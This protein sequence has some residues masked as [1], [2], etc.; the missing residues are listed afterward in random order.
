VRILFIGGLNEFRKPRGGEEFKNQLI[1]EA[2]LKTHSLKIADTHHWL[3]RPLFLLR[4]F[5]HLFISRNDKIVLSAS[6]LSSSRLIR[7]S[8]YFPKIQRKIVYIVVGGYFFDAIADNIY[9]KKYYHGLDSIIVQSDRYKIKLNSIGLS[10]VIYLP[11]FKKIPQIEFLE[12]L[13]V[14]NKVKF[15]FV[16]NISESKGVQLIFEAIRLLDKTKYSGEYEID[17]YGNI[18]PD[19][20]KDFIKSLSGNLKYKGYLD[21]KND[22]VK[23]YQ[24]LASY[25]CMLFPTM[26]VGEGFPGV[27]IDAFISSLPVIASDWH[28]NSEFIKNN[29]NGFLVASNS[30]TELAKAMIVVLDDPA[31]LVDMSK[32]SGQKAMLYSLDE[33]W[34]KLEDLLQKD[35]RGSDFK[36]KSEFDLRVLMIGAANYGSLPVGGEEFKNQI[37]YQKLIEN[38]S[39]K[40]IDTIHWKKRPKVILDLLANVFLKKYDSIIISASSLSSFRLIKLISIFPKIIKRANYF[41]I[42]GYFPKGLNEGVYKHSYYKGLNRIVL[43]G[44]LLKNEI[45]SNHPLDNV[46]VIPNFKKFDFVPKCKEFHSRPLEFVFISLISEDKGCDIIIGAVNQLISKGFGQKFTV[47]FYGNIEFGYSEKF[48]GEMS[49]NKNYKGYLDLMNK[50]NEAYLE[51]SGYD[52]LLFPSY[53]KGEGFPG[54]LIDAFIAGL[55]TIA[56]DWHMNTELIQDERNGLVVPVR[57]AFALAKAMQRVIENPE[58]LVTMSANA[59]EYASNYHID[60]VWPHIQEIV[61]NKAC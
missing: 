52:C 33:V 8:Y 45:V 43:E 38:Y 58:L 42:G 59:S 57:D 50:P 49:K 29:E 31:I 48:L 60:S 4:L 14:E 53:F 51:L 35:C 22:S 46:M 7:I 3:K 37:L 28:I 47:S 5:F 27:L 32:K 55:P 1:V 23:A 41:V 54:V 40:L 2:L 36:K 13:P 19:Y 26:Y 56:S 9:N 15:V 16:S 21:F 25:D 17:F 30:Y 11:N 12:K 34:A 10:N 61:E 24:K 20:E 44:E 18:D 39:C 6:S